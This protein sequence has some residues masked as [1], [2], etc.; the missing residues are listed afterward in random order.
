MSDDESLDM[1]STDS[2]D[3]SGADDKTKKKDE[4]AKTSDVVVK[5]KGGETEVD[6]ATGDGKEEKGGRGKGGRG[7][8]ANDGACGGGRCRVR[9]I[10]RLKQ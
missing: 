2:E 3:H 8:S 9:L 4:P 5:E 1:I 6:G 7:S 10:D